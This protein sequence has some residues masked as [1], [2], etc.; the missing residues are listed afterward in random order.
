M[1]IQRYTSKTTHTIH[2]QL[3]T[4]HFY[5]MRKFFYRIENTGS[6]FAMYKSHMRNIR[7]ITQIV[8]HIL[9]RNLFRF[10]KG[11]HVI[12]QM[13]IF[14]NVPHTIAICAITANQ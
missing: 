2:D 12:I 9:H 14:G 3:F 1:Y 10:L 4:M 5:H 13:I 7:I 6:S 8:I 11:K